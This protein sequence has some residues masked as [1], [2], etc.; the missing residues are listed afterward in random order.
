VSLSK[1]VIDELCAHQWPGNIRQL[2]NVLRAMIALRANDKLDLADLPSNYA[3]SPRLDQTTPP[4]H[5]GSSLNALATAER[6]AL[7]RELELERGNIS[8]VGRKLG[9]SRSC[10]YRKMQRLNVKWPINSRR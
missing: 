5:K 9:V 8:K 7:L 1:E 4:P 2:R 6:D 10:L 3:L